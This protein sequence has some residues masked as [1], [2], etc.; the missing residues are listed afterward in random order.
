MTDDEIFVEKMS[1]D[2]MPKEKIMII[3][4]YEYKMFVDVMS[5][6]R[7]DVDNKEE[8]EISL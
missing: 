2:K 8:K 4:M 3:I 7:I 1:L 6:V 5:A